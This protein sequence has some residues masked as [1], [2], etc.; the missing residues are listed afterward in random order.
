MGSDISLRKL[1][2]DH[3]HEMGD[4]TDAQHDFFVTV[5]DAR[6]ERVFKQYKHIKVLQRIQLKRLWHIAFRNALKYTSGN[7]Q[8]VVPNLYGVRPWERLATKY[9]VT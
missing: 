3:G 6:W 4:S 8:T 9:A 5:N 1:T 7:E 2:T